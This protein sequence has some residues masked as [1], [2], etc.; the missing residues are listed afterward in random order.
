MDVANRYIKGLKNEL[1]DLRRTKRGH[2]ATRLPSPDESPSPL[3]PRMPGTG[4]APPPRPPKPKPSPR[5]NPKS[6]TSLQRS[7]SDSSG[8]RLSTPSLK[9]QGSDEDDYEDIDEDGY[10][11]PK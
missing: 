2:L 5:K 7:K 11:M 10:E 6:V 4:E 1:E 3:P 9:K 8:F